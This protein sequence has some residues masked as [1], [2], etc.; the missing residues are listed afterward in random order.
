M[1]K[2]YNL[3]VT[4]EQPIIK[5]HVVY[6]QNVLPG[7]AYI[8]MLYQLAQDA[9]GLDYRKHCLKKLTIF[10]PLIVGPDRCVK[11]RISFEQML[12]Y[13]KIRVEGAEVGEQGKL[14]SDKLYITSELHEQA[15]MFAE[16]INIAGMKQVATA[17]VAMEDIYEQA[18]E[19]GLLHQGMMKSSG[20][21][22]VTDPGC[23]IEVNVAETY[24]DEA[25]SFLV[26]PA[27][28]D[29]A[30]M[31]SGILA[32]T[33]DTENKGELYLPLYY[34]SFSCTETLRTDCYARVNLSSL[35]TVNE[36]GTT[37]IDFFNKEGS[38]VA[39]LTGITTK[40]IRFK[41]QINAGL[42]TARS[43]SSIQQVLAT[44]EPDVQSRV[45]K[46]TG[47]NREPNYIKSV[48]QKIFTK[49]LSQVDLEID[50]DRGFFELG[51]ESSQ[52]LAVVKDIESNFAL[53]LNPTIL[54]E[55]T[56]IAEVADYLAES[57]EVQIN[58]TTAMTNE[59][60]Q[61]LADRPISADSASPQ[62]PFVGPSGMQELPSAVTI[63]EKADDIAIIGMAGR[64]PE[65][66]NLQEFW[67][68]LKIGKD[69]IVEIPKS[70]WD[71]KCL[72][73]LKSPSGKNMSKWGGF[74]DDPDCFDPQ[75]FRISPLEVELMDPQERL[76][77]ETCWETI[78]DA[79]YTPKTLALPEGP[80]KRQRVGVYV[81]VMH[82]DYTQVGSD[83][84]QRG[85]IVPLSLNCAQIANRVSYFCNFHGPSMAIDTM[86]S[87][88]LTALHVALESIKHG[89]C[90][91]ALAGGV[92][93]SL[94]P[95]KYMTY[96]LAGL[97]SSDGYCHTFGKDGDGYVSGEGVGAVLLKPLHKA[98][99]D[100]DHIYAVI[101]GSVINH[102]GKVS[103]I[104][105]PSPV[106]QTEMI[107]SCL[108][109]AAVDPRTISYIEAHGTGTSLG[110]P[111]EIEGLGKAY[112][113]YTQDLQY[114]SIGSVKSNIGH[115]EAAAGISGLIKVVLQLYYKTLVPSLHSEELNPYINFE[116]SPFYVQRQTEE[117]KQPVI[118]ENKQPVTYPR[119]AGLSGFGATGSNGHIILE[120][121]IQQ[122]S[123]EHY[124]A[125][126]FIVI[127][128]SAKNEERLQAYAKKL[129]E[130]LGEEINLSQLAYTMQVGR[131]AME[132]RV[133][134]LVKDIGELQEKLAAFVGDQKLIKNCWRGKVKQGKELVD[135]FEQDQDSLDLIYKWIEKSNFKKIAELWVK[136]YEMDWEMLYGIAKPGR[137][138]MP[139]Y[140]FAM[141]RY[142]VPES[143]ASAHSNMAQPSS[144]VQIHPLLQ[145]NTSDFAA[146]RFSS[147]FS[148][149]EFFLADHIVNGLRVLP[150]VVYLEM[151]RAAA[152][153]ASGLSADNNTRI[154]LRN[155]VWAQ[156]VIVEDQPVDVHIGLLL[157]GKGE[158]TYEIY[159]QG[160]SG[161]QEPIMH[162][163]GS[164]V[165]L[166]NIVA[167]ILDIKALQAQCTRGILSHRQCYD[168]FTALGFSY[169][170]GHQGIE[171][172]YMGAGLVLA[173]LTLPSSIADTQSQFTLHPSLMDA[174]LQA[175]LGLK[176]DLHD[177]APNNGNIASKPAL[178][179]ALQEL[180]ILGQ[181]SA[182]MWAFIRYS[183]GSAAGDKVEKLDVDVCDGNGKVCVRIKGFSLR[184]PDGNTQTG[185]IANED[186]SS[187]LTQNIMLVPVWDIATVEQRPLF[188]SA[189]DQVL[190][191]GGVNE[192]SSLIQELYPQAKVLDIQSRDTIDEIAR[193]LQ[194]Y[195]EIDHIIWATSNH[196]ITSMTEEAL[197]TDQN[198]GVMQCF[199]VI[200]ALLNLGYG[201]KVLG[202]SLIT[203]QGIPIHKNESV[204]PVH[205]S[206]HGLIG[207]MAKEYSNWKVRIIDL[208][209]SSPWPI[210]SIFTLPT[211]RQGRSWVYRDKQWYRQHLIEFENPT[212]NTTLYKTGGVYVVV[213]GAGGIGEV[214]S[215]Y[216]IRTYQAQI[217]WIGRRQKNMTIQNKLDRLATFGPIP[218]YIAADATNR[219][220][221]EQSYDE[222]KKCYS[223]INGVVHSAMVLEEHK[224]IDMEE[225]QFQ[226]VLSSKVDVSVRLAQVFKQEPI[227]FILFFSS[228]MAV[229]RAPGQSNYAAGCSFKDAF[230]HQLSREWSCAVKVINWG[231]WGKSGD[232]ADDE[233]SRA[234]VETYLRL[235]EIGIGLIEPLA[236]MET[237]E[238]L[239][240]GSL[241]QIGLIK[242][243]KTFLI[244]GMNADEIIVAT[245]DG[246]IRQQ[247]E[248]TPRVVYPAESLA[249]KGLTEQIPEGK[250]ATQQAVGMTKDL[251]REKSKIYIKKIV[252]ETLKIP[253]QKIDSSESFEKY[254]VDS[255]T[256]VLLTNK[257]RKVLDNIENTLF[258]EYQTI[259]ELVEHFIAT[260]QTALTTL[261]GLNE[262][263]F[264]ATIELPEVPS[265]RAINKSRRFQRLSQLE[266]DQSE[267]QP[268]KSP[269]IAIIGVTG[270]YPGAEN[271]EKLWDKLQSGTD[272]IT[273]VPKDRWDH[274]LYFDDATNKSEKKYCK[275][276]GFLAGIDQ[277]DPLFFNISPRE[278]GVMDPQERLFLQNAWNLLESK[279]Y[280]RQALESLYQGQ[281]GVYVGAVYPQYNELAYSNSVANRVSHFFNFHGPSI[282]VDTACSSSA[283]AIHMACESLLRGDCKMAIAGGVNLSI[284]PK[285]YVGLS[286][287]QMLGSHLD[288][289]SFSD[290]DGFIPAEGVGAVL[291]K[292]LAKAIEDQDCILAV[293]K[294]TAMNHGGHTNGFSLPNPQAQAQLLEENFKKS[295]I[296]PRT[297]SYVEAA[298]N[299]SALG[300]PM[301]IRALN[302]AFER[303]TLDKQFC[304]I[305]SIKSN[306]GHAEAASGI[307]QLTKVIL[308]LQHQQIVPSIK[309]E[310]L[311]PNINLKNT[312]FYLERE[313]Q[314]WKRPVLTINGEERELPRRAT[315]SS[316]GGG[317]S[318]VH[319][320]LEEYAGSKQETIHSDSTSQPQVVLFSAKNQERLEIVLQ[321]MLGFIESQKILSLANFSY[322]LQVG[323]EA[324]EY[325]V[326]MVVNSQ[327]ELAEGM[328]AYLK[329]LPEHK[330]LEASMPVFSGST[331][332]DDSQISS[333]LTGKVGEVVLQVLLAE[334]NLEKIALY[335]AQGGKIPWQQL[336]TAKDGLI[337]SLP[338]YP[339][340]KRRC[341]LDSQPETE[342]TVKPVTLLAKASV[343]RTATSVDNVV[344]DI[345]SGLLEVTSTEININ[346]S[347]DQ[348]GVNS[349]ILLQLVQQLQA[350]VNPTL[351]VVTLQTCSTIKDIIRVL[352]LATIDEPILLG[353][354][355]E[356]ST[357][358]SFAQFPELICFNPSCQGRPIFWI[359]GA[360]GGVEAYQIIA[361]QCERPFYG[362]QARGWMT[363]LDPIQGIQ[364]MTAYYV[365]IIQAVQP[366]GPYDLGGYSL[367]GTL[368]YEVARQL[369]EQGQVVTS[370][371]MLDAI[372][373]TE[374]IKTKI[375]RKSIMLQTINMAL[376]ATVSADPEKIA[377]TLIHRDEITI[378]INNI[379]NDN[380]DEEF[381]T[382][383]IMLAKERGLQKTATELQQQMQQ[384]AK[385]SQAYGVENYPVLP[386]LDAK[387]PCYYFRNKS[388]SYAGDLRPYFYIGTDEAL[389]DN[390]NYWDPWKQQLSH[391]YMM[392]VEAS[393]HFKLLS[394]LKV[395]EVINTFCKKI[396][397]HEGMP[398]A[399]FTA[400]KKKHGTPAV[401]RRRRKVNSSA[402]EKS[403]A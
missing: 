399:F 167:P 19:I 59:A 194:A 9:I 174:A 148:G 97:H 318:N 11:L 5:G 298:A 156:P 297:I 116:K 293:I 125:D 135:F 146:Q 250:F 119:R 61:Q 219:K 6:G 387:V 350:H 140:P 324:M 143:I 22:Y 115:A 139:T 195:D 96:G 46:G 221:L 89:E 107:G 118:L 84:L 53:S 28:I 365:E 39:Q 65:A 144:A 15:V 103:G 151:A 255:I 403:R 141:E 124:N 341:W 177:L 182:E 108:E 192:A 35:R 170:I 375:Y 287:A 382:Q 354:Q 233:S 16:K 342:L 21:I 248:V 344:V 274:S 220:S 20:T 306:I 152:Q 374:L 211:D 169:G 80:N 128:L 52:L 362:I 91:V 369:Q 200:K 41:G 98:I 244:E 47:M 280:T 83:A 349:I 62:V 94:H 330:A 166:D 27:L 213:G 123:K 64:F 232:I 86:C 13:W 101:K 333:L 234:L 263:E 308:Q 4:T 149:Q 113:S 178:P 17:C 226:V 175:S 275:W 276:G 388:G 110:D 164:A 339:F 378:D 393:N 95:T 171:K 127:P 160:K 346:K 247:K 137:I 271:I 38:Q 222:I 396:Y 266:V 321:Q 196:V 331:E 78:E 243:S 206:L 268:I 303:F 398:A 81:G 238:V 7:L 366:A 207:T 198:Q 361:E 343:P 259:D 267:F 300:D 201:S 12:N 217:I 285:K 14:L 282:I 142:W 264:A 24:H 204:N 33:G 70:R 299:G 208:E 373:C 376:L 10:E 183:E 133:V 323:R 138:S 93:L 51:L 57:E 351:D 307:S 215:E 315:I 371:V 3:V 191:V 102:G 278:A 252:G 203:S 389:L 392:D 257:L 186:A 380:D 313:L 304:T 337:I 48:L 63:S 283:V 155:V 150:G 272:C 99:Q 188:P 368:A 85:H 121:Y 168:I 71:W 209:A 260:Q 42:Q 390:I 106:A 193:K 36:I 235:T 395:R 254:G 262:Q 132:E 359:H 45:K 112:R 67:Q 336:H 383:L 25:R 261:L 327:E 82:K 69:S 153:L 68:N 181:C 295:G 360:V 240:A 199:K 18:R 74:I 316:F 158:I 26:H 2:I 228:L 130:F 179:F 292:P 159:S 104:T 401:S 294:S 8:D 394:D 189:I 90:E 173:K 154:G 347:L 236:A 367:G 319:L 231:Y 111:I 109:K 54:F 77:L 157:E 66:K 131:E 246:A 100:Q 363:D 87:S 60:Q 224:L 29:G 117:W 314:E 197:I 237:L 400:F 79:G 163:Q 290:G 72:E 311:N 381:T 134:F 335:W 258:F 216:M 23:L 348:Y 334:N 165:I 372:H 253:S 357:L 205:A 185:N 32:Y 180:E 225:Q 332:E 187:S 92:N 1:K 288:S 129:Q 105:V 305:G 162:S 265:P 356:P 245:S 239:L 379:A 296:D 328:K 273:E 358:N 50:V 114:C 269:E 176:I 320:I 340:E 325:R 40:R 75:F 76:F 37:D 136:G 120:E 122:Q 256:A 317:G 49:Y 326:A 286:M 370:I 73:G 281:V 385:V 309:V 145:H 190:I 364:A 310:K 34:E 30:A 88:S 329:S 55:Y 31:A 58:Q 277:F 291:L 386:L 44:S 230:A 345:I 56:T 284:N 384:F 251:L 242:A 223:H 227:D 352:K 214:W 312:P 355:S 322:T 218:Y 210:N 147:T 184:A 43:S 270:R 338:T 212:V 229:T 289:R 377:Q 391:F 202:W 126:G 172:V 301:E 302:K 241:D 279:G 397:S 161:D 402:I 249:Q 353:Q